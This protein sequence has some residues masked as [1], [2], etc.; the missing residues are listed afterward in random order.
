LTGQRKRYAGDK[1]GASPARYNG[2]M[3]IDMSPTEMDFLRQVLSE[4]LSALHQEVQHTDS[5]SF[6]EDLKHKENLA[7]QLLSKLPS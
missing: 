2:I 7:Q 3:N 4:R 6:K 5:R 1:G